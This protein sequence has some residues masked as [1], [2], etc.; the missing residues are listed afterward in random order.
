MLTMLQEAEEG[1]LCQLISM[2]VELGKPWQ[3]RSQAA[4]VLMSFNMLE[5]DYNPG[6]GVADVADSPNKVSMGRATGGKLLE[7]LSLV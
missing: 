5:A 7:L 3:G 2:D 4:I 1:L 6:E